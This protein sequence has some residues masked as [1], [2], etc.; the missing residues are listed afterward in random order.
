MHIML[1]IRPKE[2][3]YLYNIITGSLKSGNHNLCSCYKCT[4]LT[5]LY[6]VTMADIVLN[7]SL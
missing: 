5:I 4:L 1:D 6:S 7:K 2:A 3:I